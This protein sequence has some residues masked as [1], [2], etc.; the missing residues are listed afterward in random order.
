MERTNSRAQGTIEYLVIIA[1]VVVISLVVAG[2]ST[3][4]LGSGA[5]IAVNS[6]EIGAKVG[7]GG[8]SV[9]D[10]VAGGDENGLLVLKNSGAESLTIDKISVDGVD[11]NYS[12]PLVTGSQTGFRLQGIDAC[13]G[14]NKSYSVK[15]YYTSASGLGKTADFETITIDCAPTVSSSGNVVEE[16]AGGHSETCAQRGGTICNPPDSTCSNPLVH[17]GDSANCCIGTCSTTCDTGQLMAIADAD[18]ASNSYWAGFSYV[19]FFTVHDNGSDAG[20]RYAVVYCGV[21]V[22][23]GYALH[24]MII[25]FSNCSE[26]SSREIQVHYYYLNEYG[27]GCPT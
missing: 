7:V 25:N 11:H 23:N 16:G 15:V 3:G 1:V 20:D 22:P 8:V 4:L 18:I 27:G 24:Q 10:A 14:T 12:A 26:I 6:S 5:N 21:D 17:A 2:L 13:D 9:V 19:S